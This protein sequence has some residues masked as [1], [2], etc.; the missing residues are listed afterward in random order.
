MNLK[1]RFARPYDSREQAEIRDILAALEQHMPP[2][3]CTTA[4]TQEL[5]M[6]IYETHSRWQ[7]SLSQARAALVAIASLRGSDW[8]VSQHSQRI[9]RKYLMTGSFVDDREDDHEKGK[10]LRHG[11]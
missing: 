8:N 9:A 6:K 11:Q 10:R 5:Q 7:A 2:L 4:S 1:G 3:L